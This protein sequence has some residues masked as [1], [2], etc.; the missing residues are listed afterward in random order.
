MRGRDALRVGGF[1]FCSGRR[2]PLLDSSISLHLS[3][4]S[5]TLQL[6]LSLNFGNFFFLVSPSPT[7]LSLI[8]IVL[9]FFVKPPSSRPSLGSF[10]VLVSS[11]F[12]Q[13][14][15]S[16]AASISRII[17]RTHQILTL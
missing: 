2:L 14:F 7:D 10:S 13:P 9:F 6:S 11:F 4:N 8:G 5:A 15:W 16:L 3:L 17:S 1:Q 12:S